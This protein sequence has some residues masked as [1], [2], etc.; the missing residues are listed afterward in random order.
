[1]NSYSDRQHNFMILGTL[2]GYFPLHYYG[3]LLTLP[4]FRHLCYYKDAVSN[5]ACKS[6][7]HTPTDTWHCLKICLYNGALLYA[8]VSTDV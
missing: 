2:R 6:A 5:P 4:A 1:M 7:H 3:V 8:N